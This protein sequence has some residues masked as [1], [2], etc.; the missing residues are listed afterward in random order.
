MTSPSMSKQLIPIRTRARDTEK[1][2]TFDWRG[3]VQS[4]VTS[5]PRRPSAAVPLLPRW[6]SRHGATSGTG[7]KVLRHD[8]TPS[9]TWQ[10]SLPAAL[11][12]FGE[13]PSP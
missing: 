11:T 1:G 7:Q 2:G 10:R 8:G 6:K 4:S 12:N 13:G 5:T 9:G 3:L